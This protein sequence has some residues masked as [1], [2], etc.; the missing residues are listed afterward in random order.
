MTITIEKLKRNIEFVGKNENISN[1]WDKYKEQ[2]CYFYYGDTIGTIIDR[3]F[4][5]SKTKYEQMWKKLWLKY[6][7]EKLIT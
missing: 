7:R 5:W 6:T 1:L 2:L 4:T 3:S